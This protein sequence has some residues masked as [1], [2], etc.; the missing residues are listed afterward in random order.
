VNGKFLFFFLVVFLYCF[1]GCSQER[2]TEFQFEGKI[3][4]KMTRLPVVYCNVFNESKR[5]AKI[6]D[7]NGVF[8][9][10]AS[11]GDTLVFMAMGYL[12]KTFIVNDI[13]NHLPVNI[14]LE[15]R[16]YEIEA[17]EFTMPRTYSGFK[18]AFMEMEH[19]QDRPIEDLPEYN[20]YIRPKLLDTNY[21]YSRNFKIFHPVSGYYYKHN[22]LEQSKRNVRYLEEQELLQPEVDAK[23]NKEL[24]TQVTGFKGDTLLNFIL[25][26]NFSFNYL[27][28]STE[29]EIIEEI[30]RKKTLFIEQ[31]YGQC[32]PVT[33]PKRSERSRK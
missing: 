3:L 11:E 21:V 16:T 20:P 4:D 27:Y 19:P 26:C 15:I 17:L 28:Q 9:I 22:K 5:T 7:T 14:Q 24:I 2:T 13:H 31:C 23:Y 33:V 10:R 8:K 12:G 32:I 29:L 6:S 18:K 30:D 25:Y 1:P